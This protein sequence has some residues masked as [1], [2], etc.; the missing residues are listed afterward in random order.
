MSL[1]EQLGNIGSEVDRVIGWKRKGNNDLANNALYRALELLDLSI[2]DPR[3]RGGK[4]REL[5]RVRE[6]LCDAFV[7]DNEY[8]TPPEYF[9]RYFLAFAVAARRKADL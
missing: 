8:G 2:N 1:M 5:A 9:S 6:V 4:L 7:G 3:W